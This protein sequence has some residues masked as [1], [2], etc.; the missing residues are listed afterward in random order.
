MLLGMSLTA[1][2]QPPG[3][4]ADVSTREAVTRVKQAIV[5]GHRTRN[6]SALDGLYAESY[7][8]LDARGGLRTKAELL[9]A[10]ATDPEMIEGRY[11]IG[12][13]RRWGSLAVA[14]GHGRMVYRMPDGASR[15][16]E[17]DSV[18]VFEERGGKWWYVAAFLP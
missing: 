5:E 13:V 2:V 14:S 11:T 4:L 9:G 18:N 17:Y 3:L 7:T 15:V 12:Q 6:R 8:A 16:S 10:L 1:A